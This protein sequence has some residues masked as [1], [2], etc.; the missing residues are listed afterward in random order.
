[1][2]LSSFV[3]VL[4]VLHHTIFFP[5]NRPGAL[6]D[7]NAQRQLLRAILLPPSEAA[8]IATLERAVGS[9][10][11]AARNVA[12]V[13]GPQR[14][15]LEDA[16]AAQATAPSLR[17]E[18]KSKQTLLAAA[19]AQRST[20]DERRE[21]IQAD[22]RSLQLDY[23][24]AKIERDE[25]ARAVE[26]LKYEALSRVFPKL[27]DAAL[28]TVLT[29]LSTGDCLVCGAHAEAARAHMEA[30]LTGGICPVCHSPPA[31]QANIVAPHEVES[32]RLARM[33]RRAQQA[34]AEEAS[35]AQRF[36]AL[37]Q[38]YD[39]LLHQIKGASS[40]ISNLDSEL[41]VLGA[42]LPRPTKEIEDL[43]SQV[44]A[45][46]KILDEHRARRAEYASALR[47]ANK[48]VQTAAVEKTDVL[49]DAFAH[50]A[51]T[52]LSE[53]V[54]LVRDHT[55]AGIAQA[56]EVF[57]VPSFFADMTSAARPGMSRRR[58]AN[59]VS[60]SQRELI[61]LAFRFALLEAAGAKGVS[62]LVME[63]PEASLDEL[64]MERVGSTLHK[65][66]S[67]KKNRLIVTSNLTNAGMIGWLFGGPT[68]KK[69]EVL[70][71]HNR[72]INLLSVSAKNRALLQ[73]R[74]G[75]YQKLLARALAGASA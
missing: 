31:K 22:R 26:R 19:E 14:K 4:L 16:R 45:M 41:R 6:W 8:R 5:E 28:L 51:R 9:A 72:T 65:F 1:M 2:E 57:E 44:R 48:L 58:T 12:N 52:L 42:K 21:A 37:N 46:E 34:L 53:E 29:L 67:S 23:E 59:D 50:Y 43:E 49:R 39:T 74:A 61:D 20:L 40:E 11:S 63:T 75:R 70:L 73:D 68:R 69:A 27:E 32:S 64:S 17:A 55:Q 13:L 54:A 60:E 15:R 71:R 35:L 36:T 10:D 24:R 56:E 62:T 33:R 47:E 7:R 3:D 18:L 38:E 30:E 25:S 66:A